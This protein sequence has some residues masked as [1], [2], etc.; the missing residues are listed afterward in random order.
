ME[1]INIKI[2]LK[3]GNKN[4]TNT[5]QKSQKSKKL[6]IKKIIILQK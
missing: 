3:K 5:P 4:E 1:E 2:C 6:N